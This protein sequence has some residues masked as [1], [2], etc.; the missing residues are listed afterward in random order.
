MPK[1]AGYVDAES[2][3][4]TARALQDVKQRSYEAL[5]LQPGSH[6]LD[7]GC[8]PTIDTIPLGRLVV[9]PGW[10]LESISTRRWSPKR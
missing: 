9:L 3:K 2:L 1:G 6:V 8:G 7:V 10:S 4:R 5:H